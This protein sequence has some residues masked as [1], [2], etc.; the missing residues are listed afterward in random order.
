MA[1]LEPSV[2][3][4]A[5]MG[6]LYDVLT[7]GDDTAPASEDNFFSWATP[8]IPITE[9]DLTFLSQGLGGVVKAAKVADL[10]AGDPEAEV[11]PQQLEQLRAADTQ[12][13]YQQ[14][15]SFARLVDFVP[16]LAATTNDAFSR[17]SVMNNEGS[18][19]ER[20]EYVLRM[21]QVMETQL[22]DETKQKIEK[23]RGL[24]T[25]TVTKKNLLDDTETEVTE[26]SPLVVAY[27]EKLAAYEDAAL[28]YNT[29][30]VEALAGDS[31]RAV[32]DW[33][34]NAGIL[35]NKVKAAMSD[36]VSNGYKNEYE[37]ISA[38]IDQVMQ[39]DMALLKQQYRDDLD[40]ARLTGL[41]SGS[42]FYY[43]SVVPGNF[44]TAGGWTGFSY[45][46]TDF[47]RHRDSDY[48]YSS[49]STRAGGGFLGIFGGG[50]S[51]SAGGESHSNMRFDSDS[52][53]MSFRIAQVPIVRPWFKT[54]YLMSK[55]WR[56]D[57]GNPE[58][59]GQVVSDGG[60]P[61]KGL[62]PAYPTSL[63]CVRDLVLRTTSANGFSQLASE[64]ETH[65]ASGG[66]VVSFGPFHL[67]GSHSSG[68]GS[69]SSSSD[70]HYDSQR[71]EITV[72]G[73]QVIGFK[74][75]V[76]PQ[77][78]DPDPSITQWI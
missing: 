46:A 24:L 31:A 63:V 75:H 16:D 66:G 9:A 28:Q 47:T 44:I 15:E 45:D 50:G 73:V 52:V 25:V 37:Q 17:L 4:N 14:A 51:S 57:Q 55:L 68:G 77:S 48:S 36:W 8:G 69:G 12:G 19:S 53:S 60:A 74:C 38:F 29:R 42:D 76:F 10:K 22:P 6:K 1:E 30:R 41:A 39:R 40:K 7:N 33:A 70:F 18:L 13:L 65:R 72:P 34:I 54:A 58:A 26:P 59:K 64:W 78:P 32:H 23:F 3:L 5:I 67:G 21:S 27:N 56:F 71:Q 49:S 2:M 62:I 11:T 20:F 61:A 35:R 43:T